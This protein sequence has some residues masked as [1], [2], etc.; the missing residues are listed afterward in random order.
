MLLAALTLLALVQDPAV[1]D[2]NREASRLAEREI[3]RAEEV[4]TEVG[5]VV[6]ALDARFLAGDDPLAD[7]P[8]TRFFG[9]D[10]RAPLVENPADGGERVS[11]YR[12]G[13]PG[14]GVE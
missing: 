13:G 4:A 1:A 7:E 9:D 10:T 3:E 12:A 5:R 14:A 6:E 11:G 2:A 8:A